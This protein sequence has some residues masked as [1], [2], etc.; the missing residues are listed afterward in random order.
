[1]SAPLALLLHCCCQASPPKQL[2]QLQFEPQFSPLGTFSPL[3]YPPPLV[4]MKVLRRGSTHAVNPPAAHD[5][6][7]AIRTAT[8]CAAAVTAARHAKGSRHFKHYKVDMPNK[9][10]QPQQQGQA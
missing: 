10:H 7:P 4:E 1:M 3:A 9:H 2:P 8:P 6:P 5:V